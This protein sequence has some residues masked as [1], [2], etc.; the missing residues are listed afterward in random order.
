L[1]GIVGLT[2]LKPVGI[3]DSPVFTRLVRR[4]GGLFPALRRVSGALLV[5]A[6]L[7]SLGD[8]PGQAHQVV[9]G[10]TKRRTARRRQ[11]MQ[12]DLRLR[13]YSPCTIHSYTRIESLGCHFRAEQPT[14]PGDLTRHSLHGVSFIL[15]HAG[16]SRAGRGIRMGRKS[17]FVGSCGGRVTGPMT[18]MSGNGS[19]K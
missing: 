12:E 14:F 7:R 11:R 5:E 15:L 9:G 17:S 3:I 6:L 8:Q 1:L 2:L 10:A 13:N 16:V 4:I 19:R 18:W